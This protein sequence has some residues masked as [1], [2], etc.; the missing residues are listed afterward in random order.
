[1]LRLNLLPAVAGS[2]KKLGH[3]CCRLAPEAHALLHL[4]GMLAWRLPCPAWVAAP[5]RQLNSRE[6]ERNYRLPVCQRVPCQPVTW[7]LLPCSLFARGQERP[8]EGAAR[9]PA[10]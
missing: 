7:G 5:G 2:H 8:G 1:M 9:T 4:R 3:L 6:V 10:K